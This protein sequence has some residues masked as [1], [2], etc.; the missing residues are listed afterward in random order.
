MEMTQEYLRSADRHEES[1]HTVSALLEQYRD[2]GEP[3][4]GRGPEQS[5][6]RRRNNTR[7]PR[8]RSWA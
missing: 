3:F 4:R 2:G 8:P 6:T 5:W 7:R 1:I